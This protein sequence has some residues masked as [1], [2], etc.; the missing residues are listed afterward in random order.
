M[1]DQEKLAWT[2]LVAGIAG[3]VSL[4]GVVLFHVL[5]KRPLGESNYSMAMIACLLLMVLPAFVVQTALHYK[6]EVDTQSPDE[7]DRDI[8]RRADQLKFQILTFTCVIVLSMAFTGTAYFW[9]ATT[10]LSGFSVALICGAWV[11]VSGYRRGL[12]AW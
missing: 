3:M 1:S 12:V 8:A 7:R 4:L 6:G 10:L 11:Q 5:G 2:T 9:I